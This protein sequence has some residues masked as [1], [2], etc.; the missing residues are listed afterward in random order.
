LQA[1]RLPLV[2]E[3]GTR[4]L[5]YIKKPM[6]LTGNILQITNKRDSRHRDIQLL[7]DKVEYITSRKD[8][9]FF[10]DFEFVEE[11][12]TPL[13]LTGDCL[14]RS[15]KKYV[16]PG[17]YAF[18]VFDKVGEDY[19]LNDRKQLV[20]SMEHI[21]EEE[22]TILTSVTYS[23]TVSNEDFNRIKKEKNKEKVLK[24]RKDSRNR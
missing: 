10:Q 3:P 11:L 2:R 5:A 24:K 16:E 8:G 19:V 14:A 17:D 6:T 21:E 13:V 4:R 1:N 9:H 15:D 12:D 23:V 7:V 18:Q 20:I 22:L